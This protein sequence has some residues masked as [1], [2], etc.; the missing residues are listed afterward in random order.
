MKKIIFKKDTVKGYNKNGIFIDKG[1]YIHKGAVIFSGNII[2][3][4]SEIGECI[5]LPN[6]VIEGAIIDNKSVIGPFARLRPKT[7][8]GKGCK[9][10]NYVEVKN[11]IIGDNTKASHLSYIG[12]ADIGQNCNIGCGVVFCNYDGKEKHH[13]IVGD[14]VF[15]GSNVNI[16]SPIK[17]ES[18]TLIGAGSTITED[19]PENSLAIARARQENKP[20]KIKT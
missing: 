8:I 14:N 16:I 4:E 6:N 7:F 18:D 2:L 20:K 3:G 13:S 1:V 9:I 15:I 10:G 17:I 5:L 19:V 11:S 12:D